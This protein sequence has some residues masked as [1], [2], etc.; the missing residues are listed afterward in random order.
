MHLFNSNAN[1]IGTGN[2]YLLTYSMNNKETG[3]G[4][5][6]G[7]GSSSVSSSSAAISSSTVTDNTDLQLRLGVEKTFYITD[8][9]TA[10]CGFDAKIN[11]SNDK[12]SSNY[13]NQVDSTLT[14]TTTKL[15]TYGGGVFGKI[16]F[17]L[18]KRILIGTEA[19]IYYVTGT[20]NQ[21]VDY[22]RTYNRYPMS[23]ESKSQPGFSRESINLPIVVYL[24]LRF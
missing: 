6:A 23:T 20:N 16:N 14:T 22:T 5:R 8:K 15:L 4:I 21:T 24:L 9:W 13:Q 17:H 18:S 19:S 1:S 12:L 10:G 2:P 3:W 7:I 11:Y